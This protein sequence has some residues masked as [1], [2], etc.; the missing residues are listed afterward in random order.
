VR[1]YAAIGL[2]HPKNDHN[3]GGA[4]RAASCY[5]AALVMLVGARSKAKVYHS[6]NTTKAE[7]HIPLLHS[8]TWQEIVIPYGAQLVAVEIVPDATPLPAF[9]H[10]ER[11]LYLFGPEDGSVP[12]DLVVQ[13]HHVVQV[14]TA[15]C[16]NLAATVNVVLY[17]RMAKAR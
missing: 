16:M 4:L 17:D 3:I 11:A 14:P 9:C 7:R 8:A 13:C 5:Q 1:G 2:I 10:P 15:Y 6:A 12:K